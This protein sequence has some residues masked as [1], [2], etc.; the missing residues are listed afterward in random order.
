CVNKSLFIASRNWKGVRRNSIKRNGAMEPGREADSR[1]MELA[2]E[3]AEIAYT[4]NEV[5]IGCVFIKDGKVIAKGHNYT[6]ASGNA[7][8]HAEMV[9]IAEALRS[10]GNDVSLFRESTL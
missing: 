5:P 8:L 4:E 10:N 6:N 1:Y 9:A 3:E 2:M 7:T